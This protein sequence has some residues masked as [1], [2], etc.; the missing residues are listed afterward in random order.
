MKE[1][2]AGKKVFEQDFA[3]EN[4]YIKK[5]KT[6]NIDHFRLNVRS[7]EKDK[8]YVTIGEDCVI[9]ATVNL[10]N[11]QI[12][13]GDRVMINEGTTFYCTSGITIGNDVMFS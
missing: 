5:G 1:Q 12:N 6:S 3:G 7:P 10:E 8:V 2:E 9:A 13:I 11:A 4:N